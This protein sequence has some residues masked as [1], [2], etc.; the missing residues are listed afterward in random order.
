MRL[1]NELRTNN[2]NI[3]F[4]LENVEM[5]EKWEKVLNK[6]IGVK[7]IH[8]NS[9]LVSAQNRKRIYWTNIGLEQRGLFG[10][11]ESII[12]QPK[13]KGMLLKD[14]L[15]DKVDDKYFLSEKLI[16]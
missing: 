13:D 10:D 6:A 8:I 3:Y 2:P 5:G 16:Q 1:L 9:S 4:L 7:G 12:K 15:E 11:Y 14:I